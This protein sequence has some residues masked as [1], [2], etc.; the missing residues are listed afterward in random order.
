MG[1]LLLFAVADLDIFA[2]SVILKIQ[3]CYRQTSSSHISYKE[4]TAVVKKGR[5]LLFAVTNLDNEANNCDYEHAKLEHVRVCDHNPLPPF[6][7]VGGRK[8][9]FSLRETRWGAARL[10]FIGSTIFTIAQDF[11]KCKKK[12]PKSGGF[13]SSLT[14]SAFYYTIILP[15]WAGE[16]IRYTVGGSADT[17]ERRCMPCVLRYILVLL[18]LPLS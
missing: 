9:T 2:K 4:V 5:L 6:L 1:R 3:G 17:S 18:Q 15:L 7:S 14:N 13:R 16:T 10:P 8:K 11:Q 12:P